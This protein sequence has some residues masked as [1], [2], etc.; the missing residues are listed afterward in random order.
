MRKPAIF[1][2]HLAA[3]TRQF[4]SVR[5]IVL[6]EGAEAG[7]ETLASGGKILPPKKYFLGSDFYEELEGIKANPVPFGGNE[8]F[9]SLG[10][11]T[12]DLPF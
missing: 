9:A 3:D 12:V 2:R 11:E 8:Y 5:R 6:A 4:A 7:I 10:T 1:P